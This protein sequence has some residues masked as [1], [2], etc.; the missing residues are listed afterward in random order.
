MNS[1]NHI[2]DAEL[3]AGFKQTGSLEVLGNLYGRYMDLVYAVCLKYF[4]NKDDAKDAVGN[5][6]EELVVKL[7][8]YEVANF[9]PWLHTLAK[10]HCLMKLRAAKKMPADLTE[11]LVYFDETLHQEDEI[12]KEAQLTRM[13]KCLEELPEGQKTAVKQFYLEE[14]CYK[15]IAENTGIELGQVRSFIQNGRRNLKNCMERNP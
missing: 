1:D 12:K 10:N 11:N 5:I 7:P 8:K 2:Q 4:R 15:E 13:E 9:R 14:K 6:F 3:V